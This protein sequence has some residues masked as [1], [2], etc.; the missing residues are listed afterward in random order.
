MKIFWICFLAIGSIFSYVDEELLELWSCV[1]NIYEPTLED[2]RL[3]ENYLQ[4][5]RRPYLENLIESSWEGIGDEVKMR[6]KMQRQFMLVGPNGEMPIFEVHHLNVTEETKDRCILI[7][8]SYNPPYPQKAFHILR[9]LQELGYS[10]TVMIRIGGYPN[11]SHGGLKSCPFHGKWKIEFFKEAR[12]MG[13][14]KIIHLDTHMHPMR[15]LSAVFKIIDETGSFFHGY[16]PWLEINKNF[17]D[18]ASYLNIPPEKMNEVIFISG[19]VLGLNFANKQIVKLFDE[20]EDQLLNTKQFNCIGVEEITFIGLVW[21]YH[22]KHI[23]LTY[24]A[25]DFPPDMNDP[26]NAEINFFYD[27]HRVQIRG[28]WGALYD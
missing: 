17:I 8:G 7:Y 2:Y 21:K 20:W 23:P 4:N 13:Y 25:G 3:I 9:E 1:S 24:T 11:L 22:L 6:V 16:G 26:A 27:L 19:C 12:R 18:F 15:D 14:K 5:G 10:G 28:G